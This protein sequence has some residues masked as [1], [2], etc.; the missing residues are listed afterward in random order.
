MSRNRALVHPAIRF[1]HTSGLSL[2][3]GSVAGCSDGHVVVVAIDN[4]MDGGDV[5]DKTRG[6]S[7]RNCEIFLGPRALKIR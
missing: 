4:Q 3:D 7:L 5:L 1:E 2:G 6:E